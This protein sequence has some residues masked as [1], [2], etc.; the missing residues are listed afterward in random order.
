LRRLS[1]IT[2]PCRGFSWGP[3]PCHG[4]A[5]NGSR[6][7]LNHC[8]SCPVAANHRRLTCF[9]C[10]PSIR[11]I[12]AWEKPVMPY[13]CMSA[14]PRSDTAAYGA[15]A[16][17]PCL[18]PNARALSLNKTNEFEKNVVRRPI[19][20]SLARWCD[21]RRR[22]VRQRPGTAPRSRRITKRFQNSPTISHPRF[23]SRK[24][25]HDPFDET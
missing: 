25:R 20:D 9:G 22:R 8:A 21:E 15:R 18:H 13:C 23:G 16:I 24:R 14:P 5:Q 7:A 19:S 10:N 11:A 3:Q 1:A 17:T 4:A 12:S 2:A 6:K